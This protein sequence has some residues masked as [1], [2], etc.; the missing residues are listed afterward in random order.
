MSR[1]APAAAPAAARVTLDGQYMAWYRQLPYQTNKVQPPVQ[2]EHERNVHTG[3]TQDRTKQRQKTD[4]ANPSATSHILHSPLDL[5]IPSSTIFKILN[6]HK[7]STCN[8]AKKPKMRA[9]GRPSQKVSKRVKRLLLLPIIGH[10]VHRLR[11]HDAD[12]H[13]W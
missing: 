8:G 11:L 9:L 1:A 5:L 3:R 12:G 6:I 7:A 13:R 10:R 4:E 2:D